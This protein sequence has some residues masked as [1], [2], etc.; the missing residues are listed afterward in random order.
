MELFAH[1][2]GMDVNITGP[3][4]DIPLV[5]KKQFYYASEIIMSNQ[6]VALDRLSTEHRF[7][8]AMRLVRRT[9]SEFME[10]VGLGVGSRLLALTDEV[11]NTVLHWAAKQWSICH[12]ERSQLS[13]LIDL[14]HLLAHFIKRLLAAGSLVSATNA[15]GHTPLLYVFG[16]A[17]GEEDWFVPYPTAQI[18]LLGPWGALLASAG[19]QL[20]DY[21]EKETEILRS[22]QDKQELYLQHRHRYLKPHSIALVDE[23]TLTMNVKLVDWIE[24]WEKRPLP[25]SFVESRHMPCRIWWDPFLE[26]DED[27]CWQQIDYR[28]LESIEALAITSDSITDTEFN[29][30]HVLF[31]GP[32]DDHGAVAATFRR[33]QQAMERERN[34]LTRTRRS[35]SA[36]PLARHFLEYATQIPLSFQPRRRWISVHKCPFDSQW[37]FVDTPSPVYGSH[38]VWRTCM[39]GCR[40]RP[41]YASTICNDLLAEAESLVTSRRD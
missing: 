5:V 7:R 21:V 1:D 37:G 35:T 8:I 2:Y 28:Y 10:T 11:G 38:K 9:P 34:G 12:A 29:M 33:S 3:D 23:K 27:P 18:W 30:D 31:G 24:I 15:R 25:G 6:P 4:D 39:Q 40:G 20:V 13:A 36:A 22:L 19:V 32:Q 26:D 16:N 41:D 14:S 17:P